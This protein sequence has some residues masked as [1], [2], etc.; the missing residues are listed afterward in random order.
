MIGDWTQTGVLTSSFDF[1]RVPHSEPQSDHRT[2]KHKKHG[3]PHGDP[4]GPPDVPRA[5]HGKH[6]GS[7]HSKPPSTFEGWFSNFMGRLTPHHKVKGGHPTRAGGRDHSSLGSMGLGKPLQHNPHAHGHTPHTKHAHVPKHHQVNPPHVKKAT[8]DV[9]AHVSA[10][11]AYG[12]PHHFAPSSF[13]PALSATHAISHSFGG[14]WAQRSTI[15]ALTANKPILGAAFFTRGA[16][17]P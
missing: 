1:S 12:L 11:H 6:G 2:P 7:H 5:H 10:S 9:L 14:P 3:S 16:Y 4:H 17:T 8:K 15:G 13:N